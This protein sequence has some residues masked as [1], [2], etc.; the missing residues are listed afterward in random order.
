M[1]PRYENPPLREA[2]C[3]FRFESDSPWD[4]A[5]PGLIYS[6]LSNDFPQRLPSRNPVFSAS[7][8]VGPQGATQQVQPVDELRFWRD[9]GTGAIVL[10]PNL[11]S[12]THYRPYPS[13]DQYLPI[14]KQVLGVYREVGHPT[15]IER[16]GLRYINEIILQ[17][18][19]GEVE[20]G[21]YLD[22][23]PFLGS[24]LPQTYF[25]FIVGVQYSFN[26]ERDVLRLQMTPEHSDQP[27]ALRVI[28]D[29]DYF[30]TQPGTVSF[31]DAIGW[32]DEAHHHI[33]HTFE[34][35]LKDE[36]RHQFTQ[37]GG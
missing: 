32:V 26:S 13:W 16:I 14:I 7:I 19:T 29:L 24:E 31:D 8:A 10:R 1:N 4:L 33:Q 9:D 11:L 12:V 22:F 37:A 2:V 18:D 17:S 6:E 30:L 34:G 35:C 23:S 25:S 20:L 5:V 15:G 27:N 36:L 28:L 21:D 3:E